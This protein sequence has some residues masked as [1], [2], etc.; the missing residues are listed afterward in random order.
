MSFVALVLS[1]EDVMMCVINRVEVVGS[2]FPRYI[3][4]CGFVVV[5]VDPIDGL[6]RF[7]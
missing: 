6:A 4:R 1:W 3:H 2:F 7:C 5:I